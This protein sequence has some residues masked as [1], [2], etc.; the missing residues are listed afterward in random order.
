MPTSRLPLPEKLLML[1]PP[2]KLNTTD[3]RDSHSIPQEK[4]GL[5][6]CQTMLLRTQTSTSRHQPQSRRLWL[7]KPRLR[8]PLKIRP[9]HQ[10]QRPMPPLPPPQ[11]PQLKLHH[12]SS[13]STDQEDLLKREQ[14]LNQS[15]NHPVPNQQAPP[16]AHHQPTLIE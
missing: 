15:P 9:T 1:M 7:I 8:R 10:S 12:H 2:G 6:T 11:L 13:N 4:P 3:K 16:A 14:S 5:L